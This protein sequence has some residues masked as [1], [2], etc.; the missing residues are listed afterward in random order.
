MVGLESLWRIKVR[1]LISGRF[2]CVV[3]VDL[4]ALSSSICKVIL[5]IAIVCSYRLFHSSLISPIF[6]NQLSLSD[7]FED[8]GQ[9]TALSSEQEVSA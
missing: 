5:V 9:C 2:T 8:R 4:V 6:A 1:D 7:F 3:L